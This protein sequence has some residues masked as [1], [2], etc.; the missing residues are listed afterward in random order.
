MSLSICTALI[1]LGSMELF[2]VIIAA[3][4]KAV[5]QYGDLMRLAIATPGQLTSIDTCTHV[6]I[7]FHLYQSIICLIYESMNPSVSNPCI[8]IL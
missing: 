5:D 1:E 7:Y 3:I 4:I 8:I 2:P 6:F